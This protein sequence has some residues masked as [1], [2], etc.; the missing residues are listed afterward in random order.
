MPKLT[1]RVVDAAEVR[2]K[3]YVIWDA[4]L[5]GFGHHGQRRSPK[6]TINDLSE[7]GPVA[8]PHHTLDRT[9]PCPGSDKGRCDENDERRH[10]RENEGGEENKEAG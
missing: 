2:L 8:G 7:R 3:A 4:E 10:R 6:A 9:T 5:P 1:K